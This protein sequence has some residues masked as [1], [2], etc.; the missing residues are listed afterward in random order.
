MQGFLDT[1]NKRYEEISNKFDSFENEKLKLENENIALKKT[2]DTLDAKVRQLEQQSNDVRQYTRRDCLEI[3]GIPVMDGEDTNKIVQH[4]GD[5]LEVY[6]NPDKDISTSHRLPS[7]TSYKGKRQTPGIIV[8]FT[9][10]DTK[11][12]FYKARKAL[13]DYTTRSLEYDSDNHIFINESL[14][15]QNKI[16]FNECLKF[17]KEQEF[18][19]IW[20]SNGKTYLRKDQQSR[21]I[22]VHSL[23]EL[24]KLKA[25]G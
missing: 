17:K 22:V 1:A 18:K 24:A 19:F 16:I 10:R 8:K 6:I 23:D 7:K 4:V 5:L 14:T 15:E 20:T 21:S 9:R 25:S 2:I 3:H 11:D 13:K 12:Q